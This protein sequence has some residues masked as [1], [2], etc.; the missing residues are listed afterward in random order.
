M[1]LIG[2]YV[3]MTTLAGHKIRKHREAQAPKQSRAEFG[4]AFGAPAATV[5]GWEEQ[6]KKPRTRTMNAIV[7]TGI[8]TYADWHTPAQCFA[9]QRFADEVADCEHAGC[10]LAKRQA[11]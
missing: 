3:K 11:A 6:G 1:F 4:A 7:G 10:P 9:C 8:V 2:T 5:T